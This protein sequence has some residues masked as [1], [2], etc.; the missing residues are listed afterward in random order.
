MPGKDASR[1]PRAPRRWQNRLAALAVCLGI[2]GTA[3]V[4][5]SVRGPELAGAQKPAAPAPTA[6]GQPPTK[7]QAPAKGQP[8]AEQK[9]LMAL[10]NGQPITR[11]D[12]ARECLLHHGK[13]VLESLVNKH[14]IA[15]HCRQRNIV[16]TTKEVDVEI[17]RMAERFGLP[18]DQYLTL[19][20]DERGITREQYAKDIIWPTVALRKLADA[21]LQ[22]TKQD[23]QEAYETQFGAAVQAR[24]ITTSDAAKARELHA[25]VLQHPEQFGNIAKDKSEDPG[26]ASAKGLIQP[27][28]KHLGDPTIEKVAFQLKEGEVSNVIPAGG[29]F[30]ILK[31]EAHIPAR[32]QPMADVEKL[33]VEAI[34]DKKLRLAAKD[35]FEDLQKDSVVEN[36]FNDPQKRARNPGVAATINGHAISVQELADECIERHGK[37]T[38]SGLINHRLVEQACQKRK[39]QVTQQDLDAEVAHSALL[40]EKPRPDGK[41]DLDAWRKRVIE[42]QG[43]TWEVYLHEVVWPSV[44]L[45]KLA[46]DKVQVTDDDLR[47]G[48]EANYGPRVRCRAIVLNQQRRAQDVWDQARRIPAIDKLAKRPEEQL[49]APGATPPPA[50]QALIEEAAKQFG[51]LASQYSIEAG[52]SVL[53]GEV[54]PIQRHGAQPMLEQEAF[55]L[56]A[57]ELSGIVQ[58]ADKFVVLFCEGRTKP[59]NVKFEEV[60]KLIH[61][62]VHEKKIRLAMA[63]EFAKIQD[64]AQ[65][66]NYLA[67]TAQSSRE[68]RDLLKKAMQEQDVDPS[69]RS[70]S[71]PAPSAS[72]PS[73]A[74][75]PS[76]PR[77]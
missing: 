66:D 34:R 26:S 4:V 22:V 11:N 77:R 7:G 36:V 69:I 19:L 72:R 71:R 39:L 3:V 38:L 14:L 12:L 13:D 5:R 18:R 24:V 21:R 40:I 1:S 73:P 37:E 74:A 49:G 48:Y 32:P 46:G 55:S 23:L 63:D 57:G 67:G 28:R 65:V 54:P 62:D 20:K 64:A 51:K 50:V 42:E 68:E 45:K 8:P 47:K 56:R 16:V 70:S 27:I 15:E 6:K 58:V 59:E 61:E 10:V 52:S 41:P 29:Q 30:V 76:A 2:V 35:V 44:A 33:L 17:D 9:T 60:R 31:C 43:M 53:E 75:M 25:M